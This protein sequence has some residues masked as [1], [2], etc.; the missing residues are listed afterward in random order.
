MSSPVVKS[1]RCNRRTHSN[2]PRSSRR[3]R[4]RL[5]CGGR[6]ALDCFHGVVPQELSDR[7][8]P[9]YPSRWP[10]LLGPTSSCGAPWPS[11]AS[12]R[13]SP[14]FRPKDCLREHARSACGLVIEHLRTRARLE[15]T[16]G[17]ISPS[18]FWS[19]DRRHSWQHG[20]G[21]A[22][23]LWWRHSTLSS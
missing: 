8:V 10:P 14:A 15:A 7:R 6:C 3:M 13:S 4:W 21:E 23:D 5:C 16:D 18:V 22:L 19:R 11:H 2:A 12:P 1:L 20:V 17:S 9:G